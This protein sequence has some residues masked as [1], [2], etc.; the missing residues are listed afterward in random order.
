AVDRAPPRRHAVD[1]RTPV[2]QL[3]T[4]ARSASDRV[5]RQGV[6]HRGVRVP[7]V[8]AVEVEVDHRGMQCGSGTQVNTGGADI[9]SLDG[10]LAVCREAVQSA[11]PPGANAL[12][13]ES[14]GVFTICNCRNRPIGTPMSLFVV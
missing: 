7:E 14:S 1:Q 2:F 10:R 6:L 8:L 9:T 4:H 11:F 3:Q 12:Y 13:S 5:D